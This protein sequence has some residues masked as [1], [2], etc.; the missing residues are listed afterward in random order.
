[1]PNNIFVNLLIAREVRGVLCRYSLFTKKLITKINISIVNKIKTLYY[2]M[3]NAVQ[4]DNI[5]A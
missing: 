4:Y 2:G 3:Y 5:H 1:M